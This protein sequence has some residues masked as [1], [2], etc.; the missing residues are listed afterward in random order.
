MS[1][2]VH[3]RGREGGGF[4]TFGLGLR[5]LDA[6]ADQD[7]TKDQEENRHE[8]RIVLSQPDFPPIE[9]FGRSIS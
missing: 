4:S 9:N 8:R 2:R 1:A 5:C 3:N 6:L 7:H